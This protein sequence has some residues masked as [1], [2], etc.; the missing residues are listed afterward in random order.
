MSATQLWMLVQIYNAAWAHFIKPNSTCILHI[1]NDYMKMDKTRA[2][3]RHLIIKWI[4]FNPKI[5]AFFFKKNN[6]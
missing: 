6:R 1:N 5:Y 3:K 2:K 4:R